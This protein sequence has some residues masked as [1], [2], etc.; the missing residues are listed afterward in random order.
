MQANFILKWIIG[1]Q[2][3][4]KDIGETI[5]FST[6]DALTIGYLYAKREKELQSALHS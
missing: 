6:N 5:V 1:F 2:Q 3:R 4:Y